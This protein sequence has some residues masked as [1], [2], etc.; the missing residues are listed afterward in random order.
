MEEQASPTERPHPPCTSS[1]NQANGTIRRQSQ[2]GN[3]SPTNCTKQV[4][5]L[6]CQCQS[7]IANKVTITTAELA[8]GDSKRDSLKPRNTN[9]SANC[10]PRSEK[11]PY[12]KHTRAHRMN[13]E[14]HTPQSGERGTP[15]HRKESRGPQSQNHHA[16]LTVKLPVC[17]WSQHSVK[18]LDIKQTCQT[19]C[20]T[21][22]RAQ[23]DTPSGHNCENYRCRLTRHHRCIQKRG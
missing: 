11:S 22:R 2:H 23:W 4:I 5:Q 13:L 16:C 18:Y 10:L 3:N 17:H 7:A 14:M 8:N 1:R 6:M 9:F 20:F 19:L 21:P 12:A 15:L